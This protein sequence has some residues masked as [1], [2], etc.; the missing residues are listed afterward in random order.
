MEDAQQNE[1]ENTAGCLLS[2]RNV[3]ILSSRRKLSTRQ[4]HLLW[5]VGAS[6]GADLRLSRPNEQTARSEPTELSKPQKVFS[7]I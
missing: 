5:Y 1:T 3:L 4:R 2:D 7:L 6:H